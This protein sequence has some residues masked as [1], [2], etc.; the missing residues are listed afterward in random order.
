MNNKFFTNKRYGVPFIEYCESVKAEKYDANTIKLINLQTGGGKTHETFHAAIP[1]LF[2]D[3]GVQLIC[4]T[5]P[6]SEIYDEDAID[7]C[8]LLSNN[9]IHIPIESTDISTLLDK[10]SKYIEHNKKVLLTSTNSS[11]FAHTEKYGKKLLNFCKEQK[12][13]SAIFLDE[14]HQWST[15]DIENYRYNT[16]NNTPLFNASMYDCISKWAEYTPYIFGLTATLTPEQCTNKVKGKTKYQLL[17]QPIPIEELIYKTAWLD[18]FI[19]YDKEKPHYAFNKFIDDFEDSNRSLLTWSNYAWKKNDYFYTSMIIRTQSA[20]GYYN[21]DTVRD[22]LIWNL[23]SKFRGG[24]KKMEEYSIATMDQYGCYIYN[25][26]GKCKS[27]SETELKKLLN[28][29]EHPL[30]Y[31][32]VVER[33]KSGINIS[34]LKWYF[35]FRTSSKRNSDDWIIHN[36]LQLCGRLHR[37]NPPQNYSAFIKNYGYDLQKYISELISEGSDYFLNKLFITNSYRVC[38]P[39][40]E[41]WHTVE[42]KIRNEIS[43]TLDSVKQIISNKSDERV[44]QQSYIQAKITVE[45]SRKYLDSIDPSD[46]QWSDMYNLTET[47]N[48]LTNIIGV[49]QFIYKPTGEV[50]YIG[51]SRNISNRRSKHLTSFRLGGPSENPKSYF[52]S[53]VGV[54]MYEFDSN[55]ENYGFKYMEVGDEILAKEI[56]LNMIKYHSPKFNSEWM[57]GK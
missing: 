45:S 49:Y 34:T 40:M 5:Y 12:I 46:I 57:G 51:Y 43:N 26:N 14:I 3:M 48:G 35:D 2:D 54:K 27:V 25:L 31:L 4:Y 7:S 8:I 17:V 44:V 32:L 55:G 38:V 9:I 16:G 37:L 36:L 15:S 56:E 29:K 1:T 18:K 19:Y 52:K 28:K 11:F 33:G 6:Y 21:I 53:T 42:N 10:I 22:M 24:Y 41:I 47:I 20:D 13:L 30:R 50:L 23:R 39:D